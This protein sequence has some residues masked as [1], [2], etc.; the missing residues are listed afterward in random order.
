MLDPSL[1]VAEYDYNPFG[2]LISATGE[3]ANLFAFRFSTKYLDSETGL[4]YYGYRFY[5]PDLGRWINRDPIG[6]NGGINI[7]GM[8]GND[9][10]NNWDKLGLECCNGK[11][12][13]PKKQCCIDNKNIVNKKTCVYEIWIGHASDANSYIKNIGKKDNGKKGTPGLGERYGCIT[14]GADEPNKEISNLYPKNNLTDYIPKIDSLIT[15]VDAYDLFLQ[16]KANIMAKASGLCKT[17]C[18]NKIKV[19]VNC[20]TGDGLNWMQRDFKNGKI[21]ENPCGREYE[22]STCP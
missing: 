4:Y 3:K 7:Y 14:C 19:K 1:K 11:E 13:N 16:A 9:G 2:K 15:P 12:Y 5:S 18:C 22:I 17:D 6:E 8:V 20:A 10:V 21:K